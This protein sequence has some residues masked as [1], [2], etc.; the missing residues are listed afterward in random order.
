LPCTPSQISEIELIPT[1]YLLALPM[2]A[3]I[4]GILWSIGAIFCWGT[5]M[6]FLKLDHIKRLGFRPISLTYLYSIGYL[7]TAAAAF[8]TTRTLDH[9]D[10]PITTFGIIGGLIWAAGKLFGILAVTNAAGIAMGQSIQCCVNIMTAFLAGACFGENVFFWQLVG[11]T[12]LILGLMMVAAPGMNFTKQA[13]SA[14][15]D[16]DL[17][18]KPL[19]K[20]GTPSSVGML[21]SMCA[22][23]ISGFCMGVQSV[24]FKLSGD[25][26]ALSYAFSG[27]LAQFCVLSVVFFVERMFLMFSTESP[28]NALLN[29]TVEADT[30]T[31][32]FANGL[33]AGLAGGLLLFTAAVCNTSAVSEI[34]LVG[35]CLGQMNMVVAGIWGIA[36]FKEIRDQTLITLFFIGSF[37]ALG[38]AIL[39]EMGGSVLTA[40]PIG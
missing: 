10:I 39:L 3:W 40:G 26:D 23:M 14:K 13:L 5:A 27:S 29:Y 33:P 25:D 21:G 12:L 37:I 38:G 8:A 9:K 15:S 17:E 18:L 11:M 4:N 24:P 36:L 28:A 20:S 2:G 19:V 22:A 35:A 7:A 34:G 1:T 16:A 32:F 31:A 30:A 6:V